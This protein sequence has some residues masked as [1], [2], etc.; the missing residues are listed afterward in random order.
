VKAQQPFLLT[1]FNRQN[2]QLV[3][4]NCEKYSKLTNKEK[5]NEL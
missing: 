2:G 3:Y 4:N 5:V 1:R